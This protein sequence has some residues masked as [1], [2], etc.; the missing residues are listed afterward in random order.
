MQ[1]SYDYYRIFYYVAKYKSFT[2]AANAL[3]NNQPN[4]TRAVKSLESALGCT[5]FVRSNH[6]V[7]LTSEGEKLY[8]HVQIAF[9][10]IE[11]GEKELIL[12]KT[13]Q[14]GIISIGATEVTLHCFLLPIL[15]EYRSRYPGVKIHITNHSTPQAISSLK[16]GLV[17]FALVTTP[18][19][20]SNSLTE[21]SIKEIKEVPV[22][23]SMYSH[24]CNSPV[25]LEQLQH[26]PIISPGAVTKTFERYSDFF[27]TYGLTFTPDIEAET[28]AQ[29]LPMVKANLGIGFIPEDM[30]KDERDIYVINLAEQIPER[31][32]C[33]VKRKDHSLGAAAR[34]L[35]RLI[36]QNASIKA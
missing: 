8:A 32:I 31:E 11:A 23:G 36:L 4:M 15:K 14:S 27:K 19:V 20:K 17:D 5:L 7:T 25:P 33:L 28:T 35:E 22:C 13:L 18:T 10:H 30:L 21:T 6:G 3:L 9:E 29:I 12:E 2:S 24:L 16:N 1:I 34:E 26:Y